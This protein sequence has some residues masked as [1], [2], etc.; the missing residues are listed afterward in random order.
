MTDTS[1]LQ[2]PQRPGAGVNRRLA[3]FRAISALMLREMATRYG[4]SPGGYIWALLEPMG[5]IAV[6]SAMFSLIVRTPPLG[7]NF[8]VFYAAGFLPFMLY[9][10][11]F[12]P[13]SH[14]I[15]FSRPLLRYAAVTWI[16]AAIARLL[17]NALT[18]ILVSLILLPA[19]IVITDMRIS[20]R[21][22]PIIVGYALTLLVATGVG[23]LNCALQGLYPI[24]GRIWGIST[25]PL[26]IASGVILLIDDFP[27]NIQNIL[28]YNP[29]AHTISIVRTGFYPTYDP[30]LDSVSYVTGFGLI[31][32]F[33]GLLLT[34][35]YH[36]EILNA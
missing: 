7:N 21:V 20:L 24:W 36:R 26:V 11:V 32:L 1:P 12:G 6:L 19:I 17:L 2:P 23:A 29:L 18:S 34:S 13:V 10:S 9:S 8:L 15:S 3:S 14:C 22:E 4:Q 5:A 30:V 28:W 27:K 33:F 16:D 25:R 35:R 31:T